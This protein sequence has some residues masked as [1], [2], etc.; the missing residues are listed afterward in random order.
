MYECGWVC[1]HAMVCVCRGKGN[2]RESILSY[3]LGQD[4]ELR[5]GSKALYP[6][7]YLGGWLSVSNF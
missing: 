5:L 7:S 3:Q 4:S 1:T 2:L 6:L